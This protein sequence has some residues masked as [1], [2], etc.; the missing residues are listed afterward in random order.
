MS[1]M[2]AKLAPCRT[3]TSTVRNPV[4][5]SEP[6][7]LNVYGSTSK[8]TPPHTPIS[9]SAQLPKSAALRLEPLDLVR[10]DG[11]LLDTR[12]GKPAIAPSL[13]E[14]PASHKNVGN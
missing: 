1:L 11:T 2:T 8:S 12:A 13:G 4:I 14:E 10:F 3:R 6:C 9:T 5:C 7:L